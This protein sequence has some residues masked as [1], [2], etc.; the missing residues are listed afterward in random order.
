MEQTKLLGR[1]DQDIMIRDLRGY[2]AE[3]VEQLR[4]LLTSVTDSHNVVVHPDPQRPGIYDLEAPDRVFFIYVSLAC[5]KVLLLASW[6]KEP[7]DVSAVSLSKMEPT[8]A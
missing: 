6:S 3:L 7:S 5:D 8:V 2:P 1:L 4:T